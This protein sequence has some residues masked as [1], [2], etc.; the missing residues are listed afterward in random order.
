ML[1]VVAEARG[2]RQIPEGRVEQGVVALVQMPQAPELM[3]L[4]LQVVVVV[5]QVVLPA[6]MVM[7]VTAVQVW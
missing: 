2:L 1:V 7:V 4:L 3:E 5:D 6:L